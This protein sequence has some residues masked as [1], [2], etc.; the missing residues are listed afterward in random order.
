MASE[1]VE[2]RRVQDLP[3]YSFSNITRKTKLASIFPLVCIDVETTGLYPTKS[4]IIEITAI[5]FERGM[6]PVSCFT[7]FCKP[8]KPIPLEATRVNNIT[9]DMVADAPAFAEIAPGLTEYIRGCNLLGHN[10][11][12]DLRFLFVHGV[13]LPVDKRFFDTLDLAHYAIPNKAVYNYKLG[14]L[15][16]YYGIWRTDSHRAMSDCYATSRLL[17]KLVE[18]KTGRNL[19]LDE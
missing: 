13:D 17:V 15:C 8:K 6:I 16:S 14:T 10:L 12:F 11:D 18:D 9:D 4:E 1:A 2:R 5:R 7:T 19:V 3:E